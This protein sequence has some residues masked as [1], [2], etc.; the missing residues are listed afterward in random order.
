MSFTVKRKLEDEK[1]FIVIEEPVDPTSATP[2][3]VGEEVTVELLENRIAEA[4]AQI[5]RAQEILE[6]INDLINS[7]V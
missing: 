3:P 6:A 7:G 1:T 5:D 4:Q 2:A